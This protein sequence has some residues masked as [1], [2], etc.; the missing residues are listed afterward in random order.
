MSK[1]LPH[2]GARPA[3]PSERELMRR[4]VLFEKERIR[5]EGTHQVGRLCRKNKWGHADAAKRVTPL[6]QGARLYTPQQQ[7]E[8]HFEVAM[9]NERHGVGI[10]P[11]GW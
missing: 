1:S 3:P 9:R 10:G 2:V 6:H 11:G 7:Q 8:R 4:A 5:R